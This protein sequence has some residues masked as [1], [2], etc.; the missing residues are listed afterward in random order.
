MGAVTIVAEAEIGWLFILAGALG[1]IYYGG[2]LPRR[3]IV[4]GPLIRGHERHPRLL[5]FV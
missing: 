2:G 5:G 3:Q 1:A 4:P